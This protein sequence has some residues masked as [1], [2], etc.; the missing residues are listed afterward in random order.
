MNEKYVDRGR[1]NQK[2]KTRSKIIK[3]AQQFL[4][5]GQSF[6]L[7]DVASASGVSRAT[8]Y[9]YYSSLEA[10]SAE[11]ALDLNIQ[12]P[13]EI[14]EAHKHLPVQEMILQIQDYINRFSID[15]EA[16]FRK[17]LSIAIAGDSPETKRGARRVSTLSLALQKEKLGPEN[18][19]I[20]NLIH[21]ATVLMGME[22]LIVTKDVCRLGDQ[23]SM[24]LLRWGLNKILQA[25]LTQLDN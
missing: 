17:F 5:Q 10:L 25:T 16:A 13:E 14:Y 9:R 11:V 22:A 20:R 12:S 18:S 7:E 23:Q 1:I 8:I 3:S 6:T 21:I 2:L 19:E 4:S 24:E 15:N